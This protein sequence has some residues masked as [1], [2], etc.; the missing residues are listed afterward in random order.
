[1]ECLARRVWRVGLWRVAVVGLW[2]V[3]MAGPSWLGIGPVVC[4]LMAAMPILMQIIA[5]CEKKI[6]DLAYRL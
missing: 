5:Q 3:A 4:D 6:F 1:M 2:R